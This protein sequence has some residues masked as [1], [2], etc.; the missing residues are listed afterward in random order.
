MNIDKNTGLLVIGGQ[1]GNSG[2][3]GGGGDTPP[4]A[5]GGTEFY[6]CAA[7]Y[8]P[9]KATCF[10]F[11][12]CTEAAAN[13]T[14][15]P[16]EFTTEDWEGNKQTVYSNGDGWYYCYTNYDM[17]WGLTTDY[18]SGGLR[19]SGSIGSS[20]MDN[21][22]WEEVPGMTGVKSTTIVDADV[23]KTWDGYKAVQSGG[24]YSFESE[25]TTGL[26]YTDAK[27]EVLKIYSA[28]ASMRIAQLPLDYP[29]N[30]L[31]FHAPL[32]GDV[33]ATAVGSGLTN[34]GVTAGADAAEF[35]GS[36]VLLSQ[37]RIGITNDGVEFT[38]F[39]CINIRSLGYDGFSYP[40]QLGN[41]SAYVFSP[42]I[43]DNGTLQFM[44]N[45]SEKLSMPI[46]FNTPYAITAV[47]KD[48]KYH[49]YN[50]KTLLGSYDCPWGITDPIFR[51]GSG[52]EDGSRGLDGK[53][54]NVL[55]YDRALSEAEIAE[56]NDKFGA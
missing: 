29:T 54:K 16:T 39:F 20:W 23:P 25:A 19:F 38:L 35:N 26:T 50:G 11:S 2:G 9:R 21:S 6:R 43:Y 47:R 33:T 5:T 42:R 28:D 49:I 51:I 18:T 8:G 7:V 48:N 30:G 17:A 3:G 27:P 24:V 13:G 46:T 56:L 40:L 32:I 1:S 14:Y 44:A 31:V 36:S 41:S 15:L 22:T 52:N 45:G 55:I 34:K 10:V 53:M 4:P 37:S 12:G